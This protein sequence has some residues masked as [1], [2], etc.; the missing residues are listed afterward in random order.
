MDM[1]MLDRA[2]IARETSTI[3]PACGPLVACGGCQLAISDLQPDKGGRSGL[4]L[5]DGFL[6]N[7]LW[8]SMSLRYH[9][10]ERTPKYVNLARGPGIGALP[11]HILGPTAWC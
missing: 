2:S 9:T 1:K 4:P 6:T 5:R 10:M 3:F 11:C 8:S 7:D